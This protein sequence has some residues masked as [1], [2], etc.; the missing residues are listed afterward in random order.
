MCVCYEKNA[1]Y[2]TAS[3]LYLISLL[4]CN[5]SEYRRVALKTITEHFE[6]FNKELYFLGDVF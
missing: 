4:I 2:K 6:I 1:K 3:Y 5:V